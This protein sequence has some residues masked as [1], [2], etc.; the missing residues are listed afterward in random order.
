MKV[1]DPELEALLNEEQAIFDAMAAAEPTTSVKT[2][3]L[4]VDALGPA[5]GDP[6]LSTEWAVSDLAQ[7]EADLMGKHVVVLPIE[8]N[9]NPDWDGKNLGGANGLGTVTEVKSQQAYFGSKYVDGKYV[10]GGYQ[11]VVVVKVSKG[12]GMYT[13]VVGG[14]GSKFPKVIQV[15]ETEPIPQQVTFKQNGDIVV[16]GVIV[17]THHKPY[18]GSYGDA[19]YYDYSGVINAEHSLTGKP[20][21]FS[22]SKQTKSKQAAAGLVAPIAPKPTKP[23][24]T[25]VYKTEEEIKSLNTAL[26]DLAAQIANVQNPDLRRVGAD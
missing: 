9:G 26:D 19:G 16:N 3:G 25:K 12:N 23:K 14:D 2:N 8:A 6:I 17:G 5:A 10:G 1:A 4:V 13:Q 24:S 20:L 22:H 21:H 15:V 18:S 7:I 11:D